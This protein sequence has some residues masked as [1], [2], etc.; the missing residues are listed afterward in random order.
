MD[1]VDQL[2]ACVASILNYRF[3]WPMEITIINNGSAPIAQM[4]ANQEYVKVITPGKN[5][6]WEGGLKEGLKGV[7]SKYVMFANDDIFIPRSS[8]SW[9][10]NLVRTMDYYPKFGAIGPSS[11]V[12]MG[13]QN[14]FVEP[15]SQGFLAQF[16]IGFCVL[17]RT[18]ALNAVGGVDDTLPG[19]DDLDYSIRLRK[20]GWKLAVQKDVFV[21]HHGFQ[22]GTRLHGD[23]T[24]KNGWNSPQMTERTNTAIIKK[25]GFLAWWETLYPQVSSIADP[26]DGTDTEAEAIV[27]HVQGKTLELGCGAKKTVPDAVGVDRVPKGEPIPWVDGISVA[28]VVADVDG[29]LPF[30]DGTFGTVIARHIIEHCLDTVSVLRE[31]SRVLAPGGRLIIATPN[32]RITDGIP[33]NPEHVHAFTPETL[34]AMGKL[35]GLQAHAVI[36]EYNNIS[37]AIVFVKP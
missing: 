22:T 3:V 7:T 21:Y 20:A 14:I 4:F 35:L 34:G 8:S 33:L 11:N 2:K 37:F 27:P 9:L 19:G 15:Y 24:T 31:W 1:N 12:V 17:F 25:H 16:L 6:G 26:L 30:E 28:D 36:T 13:P 29:K 23:H 10:R 5:L 18:E 32:E